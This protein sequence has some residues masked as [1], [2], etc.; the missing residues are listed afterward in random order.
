MCFWFSGRALEFVRLKGMTVQVRRSKRK[1]GKVPSFQGGRMPLSSQ[2]SKL[3]RAAMQPQE[4]S[5]SK[6]GPEYVAFKTN[7][8]PSIKVVRHSE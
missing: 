5:K 6:K 8:R 7:I 1:S 4:D 3:L 2:M